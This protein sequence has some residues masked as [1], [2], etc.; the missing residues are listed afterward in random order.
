MGTEP[1]NPGSSTG[2]VTI[3]IPDRTI[4]M[5]SVSLDE[6][7][8]MVNSGAAP[9]IGFLGLTFGTFVT[10]AVTLATVPLTD[11]LFAVFIAVTAVCLILSVWF[12]VLAFLGYKNLR[13]KLRRIRSEAATTPTAK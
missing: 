5:Y 12:G 1:L 11:R 7:E 2:Q 4:H 3:R 9:A 6:L 10:G 13:D 8:N